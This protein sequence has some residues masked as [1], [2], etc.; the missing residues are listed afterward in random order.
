MSLPSDSFNGTKKSVKS[1]SIEPGALDHVSVIALVEF[2]H[3]NGLHMTS[4]LVIRSSR[5]IGEEQYD[6]NRP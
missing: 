6:N 1:I 4:D 5:K 3:K 2:M